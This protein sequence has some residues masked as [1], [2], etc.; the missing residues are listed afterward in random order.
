MGFEFEV[1]KITKVRSIHL[2]YP[3]AIK[4]SMYVLFLKHE[5][6]LSSFINF[7]VTLIFM[8]NL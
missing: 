5:K 4:L 8:S 1:A 2:P 6:S 3:S 7:E